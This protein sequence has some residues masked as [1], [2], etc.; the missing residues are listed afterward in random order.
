MIHFTTTI[1]QFG[2]QGEKTGWHYIEIPAAIAQ[3]IKPGNK[4]TFRVKGMLDNYQF[5]QIALLPTGG[6]SFIM[7]LNA[8]MRKAIRKR[9]GAQV[10]VK[11]V[12]DETPLKPPADFIECLADEPVAMKFFSGL[13]K[14]H[15]NY[16]GKWID[17]A[18]TEQT[19]AK[20]I[21]QSVTALSRG[22]GYGE[23]LRSLKEEK[24]QL[25]G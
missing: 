6:G 5:Q 16:F 13:A 8:T 19:K 25:R 23:M 18:K 17:S 3:K 14:S 4:K 15:Q 7:A 20:R 10:Q 9:K 11:L 22:R 1:L 21:A 12:E 2:K 24:N